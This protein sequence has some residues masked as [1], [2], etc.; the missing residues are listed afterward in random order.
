KRNLWWPAILVR[1]LLE[2]SLFSVYHVRRA[3]SSIIVPGAANE[4]TI[5]M[6]YNSRHGCA[7]LVGVERC[8]RAN[9]CHDRRRREVK[10]VYDL[11]HANKPGADNRF[12]TAGIH[13][14]FRFGSVHREPIDGQHWS[15]HNIGGCSKSF[16]DYRAE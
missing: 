16:A 14:Y 3:D 1:K 13:G 12:S 6:A 5:E 4:I 8:Q 9:L 15:L 2:S 11:V 7:A 10:G